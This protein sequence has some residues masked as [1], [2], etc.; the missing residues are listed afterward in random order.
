M[1]TALVLTLVLAALAAIGT[2][3]VQAPPEDRVD[4]R[5]YAAWLAA[6]RPRYG[7]WTGLLDALQLF[8]VFGSVWFKATAAGLIVSLTACCINRSL[9]TWR[10]ATS[11]RGTTRPVDLHMYRPPH[12][13]I[14][15]PLEAD[16]AQARI[17]AVLDRR[18][19]RTTTSQ[20]SA[21][22]VGMV[23]TRFRWAPAASVAGHAGVVLI[24]L[25]AVL[26]ST[27]GFHDARVSVPVGATV[28]I[29]HG[30]GLT[31]QAA[32]FSDFYYS[33]GSPRDFASE[34]VLFRDGIPVADGTV[35]VNEPLRV[36]DVSVY[37]SY[38]GPSIS[39]RVDD[40]A[41]RS[42]FLGDVP[43]ELV[44]ADGARLVGMVAIADRRS[45][46]YVF[47]PKS[48]LEDP[49]IRA[50]QIR[51]RVVD[52]AGQSS[53]AVVDQ[54]RPV[55]LADLKLT[56]LREGRFTGLIVGR[57]P[58]RPVVWFGA[59]LLVLG[60]A[61]ALTVRTRHAWIQ[62][63]DL[64]GTREIRLMGPSTRARRREL[65]DFRRLSA[66]IDAA[67]R[68]GVGPLGERKGQRSWSSSLT[69][70]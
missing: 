47:A 50:G 65:G 46:I 53:S 11:D 13:S 2:V 59:A 14:A 20:D 5:A 26:G 43:L 27:L 18:G 34:L 45:T 60:F 54:G 69:S 49:E 55:A 23:A 64:G 38:F 24:V 33:D 19:Y 67:L 31:M 25:G 9:V 32:G 4:A 1:R 42:L 7:I 40:A 61:T 62:I 22:T 57:D 58:G 8:G 39:M 41:G 12:A 37:Q 70:G 21:T 48:G 44:T 51:V 29:G 63:A 6:V 16:V 3:I 56:F 68:S 36:G 17:R 30:T 28:A 15:T 52:Q 10:A 66:E 35:R